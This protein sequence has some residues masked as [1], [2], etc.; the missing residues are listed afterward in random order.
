MEETIQQKGFRIYPDKYLVAMLFAIG[1][2]FPS[3]K[4]AQFSSF[5]DLIFYIPIVLF[6]GYYLI[7][8]KTYSKSNILTFALINGSLILFTLTASFQFQKFSFGIYPAFF[9]CSCV[10]LLDL[11][12]IKSSLNVLSVTLFWVTLVQIYLGISIIFM[13]EGV[14]EFITNN[15][16]TGYEG[17]IPYMLDAIKPINTFATHSLAA[18]IFFLFFLLNYATYL[19][20]KNILYL[21]FSAIL[22]LFILFLRSNT[23]YLYFGI[24]SVYLI[25]TLRKSPLKLIGFLSFITAMLVWI[26]IQYSALIDVMIEGNLFDVA[27]RQGSGLSGRYTE[28]NYLSGTIEFI[29]ENPFTPIGLSFSDNL[30][31]TDSGFILYYLRGSIFLILGLYAGF[32]FFLKRNIIQGGYFAG[33]IFLV[34]MLF[35]IGLPNLINTRTLY[36]I[37]FLV[38]YFNHLYLIKND[39]KS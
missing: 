32:Y 15:Y 4:N 8:Q 3:S 17:L 20:N 37:P 12:S 5:N 26:Y 38:V 9:V 16:S 28:G 36:I 1:V 33:L 10:F 14:R 24:A 21:I 31:F 25:I 7:R 6:L 22:L 11:K 29:K 27:S 39:V 19:W 18:F 34:F 30:F 2:Y 23:G 35:E 13:D